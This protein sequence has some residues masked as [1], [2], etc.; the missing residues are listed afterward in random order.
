MLKLEKLPQE[1]LLLAR[2][3]RHVDRRLTARQDRAQGD[4]QDL[5]QIVSS[6]IAGPRIL[7]CLKALRKTFHRRLHP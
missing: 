4:H 1:R 3:N 5:Q 2:E 7:K 6:G